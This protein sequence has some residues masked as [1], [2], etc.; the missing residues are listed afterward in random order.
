M[1]NLFGETPVRKL[2]TLHALSG[3]SAP[4][5]LFDK[6]KATADKIWWKGNTQTSAG[7][8]ASDKIAVVPGESYTLARVPT[9]G[10]TTYGQVQYFN[11][12]GTYT[13]QDLSHWVTNPST[14]TIPEGV[15]F[16]AFNVA[17]A[18]IDDATFMKAT[19]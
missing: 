7:F 6:T 8:S 19:T 1:M 13:E 9:V 3:G 16:M 11:S 5:N 2:L 17:T 10:T 12:E 15:Y 14:H 4:K 18:S